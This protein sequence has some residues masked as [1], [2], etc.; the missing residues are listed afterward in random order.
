MLELHRVAA[1]VHHP[2]DPLPAVVSLRQKYTAGLL[3]EVTW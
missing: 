2:Q 3:L 1:V